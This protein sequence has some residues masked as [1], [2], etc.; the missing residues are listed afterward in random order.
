VVNR[1]NG[2]AGGALG[3]L[4]LLFPVAL[5][6][7]AAAVGPAILYGPLGLATAAALA[8]A[9]GA[10]GAAA[11]EVGTASRPGDG[12]SSPSGRKAGSTGTPETA[13]RRARGPRRPALVMVAIPLLY[14]AWA[15]QPPPPLPATSRTLPSPNGFGA[16]RACLEGGDLASAPSGPEE[17][18]SLPTVELRPVVARSRPGLERL[19]RAIRLEYMRPPVVGLRGPALPYAELRRAAGA[20]TAESRRLL[21][22]GR[23]A[24][25]ADSALDQIEMGRKVAAGGGT[26]VEYLTGLRCE[27][28]GG[29]ALEPCVERLSGAEADALG[30]RLD[31]IL[32]RP[33]PV[34]EALRAEERMVL[35]SLQSPWQRWQFIERATGRRTVLPIAPLYPWA[36]AYGSYARYI[37][38]LIENAERPYPRRVKHPFPRPHDWISE[39]YSPDQQASLRG[40]VRTEACLRLQRLTLALR[41]FRLR[42]RHLPAALDASAL[43]IPPSM[44]LDPCTESPL[45]YRR[46]GAGYLLYSTGPDEDDDAGLPARGGSARRGVDLVAGRLYLPDEPGR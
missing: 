45:R 5:P 21:L 3:G 27:S 16:L 32:V 15:L 20:L 14:L 43:R 9:C 42:R 1:S 41:A 26:L 36:W 33:T 8:L 25:A 30:R 7:A 24:A 39:L 17:V 40:A 29:A 35:A 19:R 31:S 6:L 18:A 11:A 10:L 13:K 23:A 44:V 2:A 34:A 22:D 38:R 12:L 37:D 46:L 28:F 4:L